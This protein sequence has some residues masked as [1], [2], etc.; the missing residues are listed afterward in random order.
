MYCRCN[1]CGMN[2]SKKLFLNPSKAVITFLRTVQVYVLFSVSFVTFFDIVLC[3]FGSR[4]DS[5]FTALSTPILPKF[6]CFHDSRFSWNTVSNRGITI[7]CKL[8]LYL[9]LDQYHRYRIYFLILFSSER[10]CNIDVYTLS[11]DYSWDLTSLQSLYR[12]SYSY[13]SIFS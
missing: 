6:L 9:Y 1:N 11:R 13:E 10:M 2:S 4:A 5:R 8:L 12:I 7:H 3:S